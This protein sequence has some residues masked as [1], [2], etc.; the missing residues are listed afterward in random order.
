MTV[1]PMDCAAPEH[2]LIPFLA[3]GTLDAEER[4]AAAAHA[5]A[6]PV[7]AAEL[8]EVR[9]LLDGLR[10]THLTPDEIVEAAESGEAIAHL[11]LC[12][13][14]R[15]ERDALREVNGTLRQDSRPTWWRRPELA[16]A[17][18]LVMS[19]PAGLFVAG[20]VRPE[21][22]AGPA[23]KR[24]PSARAMFPQ[25][26][27]LTPERPTPLPAAMVV[28][29]FALPVRPAG[30]RIEAELVDGTGVTLW[31]GALPEGL[32]RGRLV[33]DAQGLAPGAV[34]E[35]RRVDAAGVEHERIAYAVGA[36]AP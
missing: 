24:G 7:C 30:Q 27:V 5:Q 14:C 22:P 25:T 15:A 28:L 6:C 32:D 9:A 8:Q 34:L 20:A 29:E 21:P 1:E 18:A 19:V 35:V 3:A 10:A 33:L 12:A 36:K 23:V 13:A 4:A 17:A 11:D 2:G 16:W 31:S 26:F